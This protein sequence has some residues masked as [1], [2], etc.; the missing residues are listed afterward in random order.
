MKLGIVREGKTPP[1]KRVPFSPKQCSEIIKKFNI[2][3]VV[4]P[5]PIRAY[6]DKEYA[7]LGIT[8]QEN[9]SDC[10]ILMG[11]KEV[12]IKDLIDNKH[13]FFFSHTIKKQPYNSNLLKAFLDK[14]IKLTDYETLTH[15][16][17]G[18]ILGFGR[19][20]G[21][22]GAYNGLLAWGKRN[23]TFD[24]KPANLCEDFEEL[25]IE[26]KKVS[27]GNTK[28]VLTGEGRVAKGA[29]EIMNLI[30]IKE[31]TSK[32]FI[33]QEHLTPVYTQLK[34]NNYY[35]HKKGKEFDLQHLFNNPTEYKSRFKKYTQGSDIF[36]SCHYWDNNAAT[37]F[38]TEDTQDEKFSLKVIADITCDIKGSVPTTIRAS[39]IDNPIY[40]YNPQTGAEGAPFSPGN[41]TVMAVDNLPCELPRDA[42]ADFGTALL[43]NIIPA[44][45]GNDTTEIINRASI[46]DKGELNNGYEYLSDYAKS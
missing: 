28:I 8:L 37:L 43:K 2:S 4:Q 32:D 40:G 31:V 13:Y 41:I 16:E 12:E 18:R 22:V 33:F 17:G 46:T 24:L 21:I 27:L 29:I 10:D 25:K 39:T 1:D 44:I 19:Y 3:L 9:L 15:K 34:C 38:S 14:K 23:G 42:S 7:D 45:A 36:I 35:K 5:S 30:E 11:V 6:T 26:L 20:A